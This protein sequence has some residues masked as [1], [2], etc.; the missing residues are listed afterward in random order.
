MSPHEY[1]DT[2]GFSGQ[3]LGGRYFV[4]RPIGK[5]AFAIVYHAI[6]QD[7]DEAAIKISRIDEKAATFRFNREV[8]VMESLP[9]SPHLVKYKSHGKTQEGRLF[10]AMEFVP[11]PTLAD[12]L[13]TRPILSPEEAAACVGQIALALQ[14]LH[15]FDIV[16]RDLKPS[17]VLLASDGLVKL[18]DFGLVLDSQRML[19]MFESQ[20][21]LRGQD[22]AE[23]IERGIVVGTPEYMAVEQFEDAKASGRSRQT[24]PASDVFSAG[25][26]L[27]R[28][29]TGR[30][31]FPMRYRSSKPTTKEIVDYLEWRTRITA[32]DLV[33][34]PNVDG[35]LWNILSRALSTTPWLRQRDGKALADELF[36]YVLTLDRD[37]TDA[38]TSPLIRQRDD[39]LVTGP[40]EQTRLTAQDLFGDLDLSTSYSLENPRD[41]E[42]AHWVDRR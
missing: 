26:I 22:F 39:T 29:I 9:A 32:L 3:L 31:P 11:G 25:V 27:Y 6:T 34:P 24:C 35:A 18:F 5:G 2:L 13:R 19:R 1:E 15:R 36:N 12:G 4:D 17:N 20:D 33:C 40:P 28:L 21:I 23:E 30:V 14:T 16:H 42:E 38:Y 8:K 41:Y 10:L 37:K 7:G